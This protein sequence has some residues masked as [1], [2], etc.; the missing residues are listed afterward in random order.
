MSNTLEATV[1]CGAQWSFERSDDIGTAR[2]ASSV[3]QT[4]EYANGEDASQAT[5]IFRDRLTLTLADTTHDID[6]KTAIDIY[7]DA[8]AMTSVR[9]IYLKNRSA[10]SGDWVRIGPQSAANA[11][12]KPWGFVA[13]GYNRIGCGAVFCLNDP[14]DGFPVTDTAKVVRIKHDGAS[15][16]LVVDIAIVGVR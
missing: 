12:A 5:V 8:C 14:I 15:Y 3:S 13:A 4:T 16:S 10:V 1:T 11:L 7:G 6:L 2:D 9:A